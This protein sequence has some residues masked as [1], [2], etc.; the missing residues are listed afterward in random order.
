[1][2]QDDASVVS[3]RKEDRVSR[4]PRWEHPAADHFPH[5]ERRPARLPRTGFRE[6]RRLESRWCR[7]PLLPFFV[8]AT[9]PSSPAAEWADDHARRQLAGKVANLRARGRRIHPVPELRRSPNSRVAIR[10]AEGAQPPCRG[11]RSARGPRV[12]DRER[13]AASAP[14]K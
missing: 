6:L 4:E 7:S 1:M 11:R 5:W 8:H 13:K 9:A 2:G 12:A 3:R 10:A 14:E